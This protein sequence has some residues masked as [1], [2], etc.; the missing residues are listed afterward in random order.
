MIIFQVEHSLTSGFVK[1]MKVEVPVKN[2][3]GTYWV[4]TLVMSCGPLLRVRYEGYGEDTSAD[5]WCD[6][7]S[8]E[9]H[10]LGWCQKNNKILKPPQGKYLI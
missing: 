1:G 4:A 10:S 2:D 7:A 8:S 6:L 3:P 9:I 5:F